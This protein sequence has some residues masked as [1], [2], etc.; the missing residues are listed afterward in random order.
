MD[1]DARPVRPGTA[2]DELAVAETL[3]L[4]LADDPVYRWMWHGDPE[5]TLGGLR[6]WMRLVLARTRGRV[7][8]DVGGEAAAAIWVTPEAPLTGEDYGA[9]AGLLAQRIGDRA[10]S[11]MA[12]LVLTAALIPDEPH[13]TLL[14]VGVRPAAQGR[15]LGAR[16]VRPG[17]ARADARH[18]PAV[19]TSTNP[20]NVSFYA[21]LGFEPLGSVPIDQT[22]TLQPMWRP[23]R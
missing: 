19:V 14:Y 9:V 12:V 23:A 8:V 10:G 16:V 1:D 4:A 21:R 11:V 7:E 18:L 20:R 22:A 5:G 2:E 3:A 6:A 15:G 13:R 17:L